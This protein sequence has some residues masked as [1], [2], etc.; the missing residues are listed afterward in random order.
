M[1]LWQKIHEAYPEM[2]SRNFEEFGIVLRDDADEVGPYIEKWQYDKPIP[3]GLK[4]GK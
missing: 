3:K 1:D 2:Q 4:L